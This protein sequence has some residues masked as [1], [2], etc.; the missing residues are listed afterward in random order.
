[1]PLIGGSGYSNVQTLFI[2]ANHY[3]VNLTGKETGTYNFALMLNK[4]FLQLEEVPTQL[5]TQDILTFNRP[6]V[7]LPL[8]T[9]ILETSDLSKTYSLTLG[10]KFSISNTL[11]TYSIRK[12]TIKKGAKAL[13]R[14]SS[15]FNSII[16]TNQGPD[17]VVFDV[18]FGNTMVSN[19][20]QI[21][22]TIPKGGR[23]NLTI[24]PFTTLV[25][26][27]IDWLNLNQNQIRLTEEECGNQICG[28]GEDANN[29]SVDCP[30]INS[31]GPYDNMHITESTT[32]A[33]GT[34]PISDPGG[35][36]VLIIERD[37]VTLD[38]NGAKLQGNGTG[39]GIVSNGKS[40]VTIK[41]CL[42]ENYGV[43][44]KFDNNSKIKIINSAVTANKQSGIQA[45]SSSNSEISQN[46]LNDNGNG[47]ELMGSND[48]KVTQNIICG[49][50]NLDINSSSSSNNVGT[51]NICRN[52]ND[53]EE[54][55]VMGCT[56]VCGEFKNLIY[57]PIILKD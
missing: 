53:W 11:R 13:F 19:K 5:A 48:S 14:I 9:Y 52:V 51:G 43:G 55:G 45:S 6:N 18:E 42:I 49:N 38:C 2:P 46:Y 41:N 44:I 34:Y 32:L 8:G 26:T 25:L 29:C 47:M 27:P 24:N 17:P 37:G 39:T 54:Q 33:T 20:N 57:L 21:G 4:A 23:A 1:M 12:A 56:Y 50:S 22:D 10:A 35:D 16:F 7:E 36:G 28:N 15:D 30:I 40:N 3:K 31:Q